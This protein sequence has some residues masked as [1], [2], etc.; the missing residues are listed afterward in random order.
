MKFFLYLNLLNIICGSLDLEYN[1][2]CTEIDKLFTA[3]AKDE[4]SLITS[5]FPL[6]LSSHTNFPR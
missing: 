2:N 1:N 3:K 6:L 4:I 5:K